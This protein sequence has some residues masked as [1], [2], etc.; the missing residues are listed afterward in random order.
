MAANPHTIHVVNPEPFKFS[1][2]RG[3]GVLLN[4]TF[5]P[6]SRINTVLSIRLF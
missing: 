2:G 3:L 4:G 1:L 5:K 6:K